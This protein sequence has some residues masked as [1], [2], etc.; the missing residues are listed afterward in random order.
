MIIGAGPAGLTAALELLRRTDI[1]PVVLEQDAQAGGISRTVNCGGNRLDIGG[2]RFFTKSKRVQDFW[3]EL[4]P[5]QCAPAK[6]D[7]LLGR[8]LFQPSPACEAD[9][10]KTDK[11]MLVRQR[12]SRILFLQKFFDYPVRLSMATLRGLGL[13]RT[14]KI[15][16]SYLKYSAFP[17]KPES[18][19]E[20]FFTNRFG[21]ELYRTFFRDY[22]E[23]VWGVPCSGIKP[24]WGAQR[25]KGLSVWK[26]LQ[27]AVLSGLPGAKKRQV[28]TSL[29]EQFMYPKLGPGQLWER[30]AEQVRELGGEVRYR[31]QVR[32]LQLEGKRVSTVTARDA[33]S[34]AQTNYRA[35]FVFSSMPVR[36][37]FAAL[38]QGQIPAGAKAAAA[39]LQYRDFITAGVLL[40]Q[41]KLKNNTPIKTVEGLVP[42]SW[43]YIQENYVKMGRLQVFNNW[44]PYLVGP[45]GGVWLGAEY[46]C[47]EGDSFWTMP[48]ADIAGLAVAELAKMNIADASDVLETAVVR[49]PKA[50]PAYF[51]TY[52]DFPRVRDFADSLENLYLVGRNGMHR[53]NNQ[54]HSMLSAMTAVDNIL[55]GRRD[56]DNVW[57]VNTEQE[58]HESK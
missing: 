7:I 49:S 38:P 13:G 41:L 27:H 26:A 37:L 4:F 2:H 12:I 51:G 25:V 45:R 31:A 32:G 17:V 34:G 57:D 5:L 29:I 35:D 18:S 15:G 33:E 48:D 47:N 28:E 8:A 10:E 55:S 53:Y 50:Y 22:T 43:I 54:D 46:F 20:D 1:K 36:D 3:L 39:G 30:A 56:R 44:S 6:D 42:D 11:V 52:D 19:L 9:P 14:V 24:E 21:R 16:L 23:K 40:K 58:Y